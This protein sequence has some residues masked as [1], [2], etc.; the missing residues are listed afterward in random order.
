[1]NVLKT[2]LAD[3]TAA[4][5]NISKFRRETL[6]QMAS[7]IL[8]MKQAHWMS[9]RNPVKKMEEGNQRQLSVK[10]EV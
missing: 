2:A 6:P 5:T 9:Q 7:T 8:E 3:I 10:F 4:M 1:M